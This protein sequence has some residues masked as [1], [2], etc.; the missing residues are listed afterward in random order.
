[1]IPYSTQLIDEADIKA[2]VSTLQSSHLTQGALTQEFEAALAQRANAK[3]AISFNSATSALYALYGAYMLKTYP[4]HAQAILSGGINTQNSN[5]QNLHAATNQDDEIYFITT[6]ISFVA[7]TNMMLQWGIKPL[8][9]DIKNDG[10]LDENTLAKILDTH[11]KAKQIRAIVSVDYA[12]KSVEVA[13]IK[14]LAKKH[15]LAFFSDSSHSFG[16]AYQ[17][18]SIGSLADA[19]I[20]SFHALKSITTAEGGAIVTNDEEL[21]HYARLI[22]SHG[23]EK[24]SL[25]NYDCLLSGMNFRLSELGA[26]LGLSQ[27][28]KLDFFIQTRHEIATFYD[29]AFA[30]SPHFATI[31][32]ETYIKSSHHLYP[33]LLYPHLWC[34][35]EEIFKALQERGLGVQVHY[36]PIYQFSFYQKL[37]AHGLSVLNCKNADNFYLSEI[38]IPCHQ[39]LSLHQAKQIVEIITHICE[40]LSNKC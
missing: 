8:F 7:T 20:F 13:P 34:Q 31:P 15:N 19:T 21:A 29:D 32:I 18:K 3:Y 36:K 39:A 23:V 16:G 11:P 30:N 2:V 1:M 4:K 14:A 17:G 27:L 28:Q 35:K 26:A 38:S 22:L 40:N 6:P 5:I 24:K 12:G 33:I 9:C 37:F 25:W 10:N